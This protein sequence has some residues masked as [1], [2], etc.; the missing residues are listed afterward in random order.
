MPYIVYV[1]LFFVSVNVVVDTVLEK[2]IFPITHYF[3]EPIVSEA[4]KNES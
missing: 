2:P 1:G 4:V 3:T